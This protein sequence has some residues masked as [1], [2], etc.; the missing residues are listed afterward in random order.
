MQA[1]GRVA[2]IPEPPGLALPLALA[3]K[4][5]SGYDSVLWAGAAMANDFIPRSAEQEN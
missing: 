3:E 2:V 5:S 1:P 4:G